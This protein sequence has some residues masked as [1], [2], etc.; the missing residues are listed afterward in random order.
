MIEDGAGLPFDG[1]G[2][3][4][5]GMPMDW[6]RP[7]ARVAEVPKRAVNKRA[8]TEDDA[9]VGRRI[10][11]CRISMGLSLSDLSSQVGV[12]QPQLYR[13]E[14]GLT[15]VAASRLIAIAAALGVSIEALARGNQHGADGPLPAC[16]AAEAD[17]LLRAFSSI[18][19][20]ERRS[21]LIALARSMA[22]ADQEALGAR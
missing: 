3:D 2:H 12:S 1:D 5:M 14:C 9:A 18:G 20:P 11:D 6:A 17:L 13:Y 10:R 21:A 15:R 7:P 19:Q 4:P 8:P 16:S 22:D